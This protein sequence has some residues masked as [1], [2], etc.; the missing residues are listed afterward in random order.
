MAMRLSKY[1]QIMVMEFV[2]AS[3]YMKHDLQSISMAGTR[4]SD[5]RSIFL[6]EF[7]A[8]FRFSFACQ[9]FFQCISNQRV[10]IIEP[11]ADL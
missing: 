2:P 1:V 8:V 7:K 6:P 9:G 5:L 3:S 10:I 4:I 11:F